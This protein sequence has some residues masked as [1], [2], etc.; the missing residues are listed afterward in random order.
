MDEAMYTYLWSPVVRKALNI[1]DSVPMWPGIGDTMIN[2]YNQ[3]VDTAS[4]YFNTIL[5]RYIFKFKHI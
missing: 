3:Q 5:N 4:S 2:V 1:P